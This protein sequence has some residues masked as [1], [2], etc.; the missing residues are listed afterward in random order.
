MSRVCA[1]CR[2][3]LSE[4][5]PTRCCAECRITARNGGLDAEV[6]L[7][8]IGHP[9]YQISDR[10]RVRDRHRRI[11]T[12]EASGRYP[13]VCLGG[14]RRY[15]HHLMAESWL[16]PRPWGALVLHEDDDGANNRLTN[17]SWGTPKQNAAD[18]RRN[19]MKSSAGEGLAVD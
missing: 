1:I 12:P 14:R 17:I 16:G 7:P 10:G 2:C 19:R 11:V 18:R 3:Q 4:R 6:W 5:N 9:G 8:V 15:L 13:R